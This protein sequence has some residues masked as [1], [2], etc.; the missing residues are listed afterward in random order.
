[1]PDF[2]TVLSRTP[3]PIGIADAES[4]IFQHKSFGDFLQETN[5]AIPLAGHHQTSAGLIEGRL[6]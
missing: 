5:P 3:K 2:R 6:F 1:M 4:E